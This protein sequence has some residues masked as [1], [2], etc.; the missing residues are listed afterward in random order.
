MMA[1]IM[2][3]TPR[4]FPIMQRYYKDPRFN[5]SLNWTVMTLVGAAALIVLIVLLAWYL[6]RI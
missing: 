4:D 1:R 5:W 2:G 3:W 6:G